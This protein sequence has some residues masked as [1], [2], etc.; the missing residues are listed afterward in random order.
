MSAF[1]HNS[2]SSSPVLGKTVIFTADDFGMSPA[3]NA[4]VALAHRHGVLKCA[5]LMVTGPTAGQAV[6]LAREMPD[7]CLGVHLTLIQ[8]RSALPPKDLPHLVDSQGRF[9]NN[10]V[11][12]GWRY[13]WQAG[14]LP[15]IRRELAAQI[16]AALAK[17]LTIWFLNSH[18]N[19]HL[20]P[21][22]FPVV[23]DLAEEYGI[24]AIRLVR[25]NWRTAISLD[26][27]GFIPKIA[28]GL[29][30]TWLCRKARRLSQAAGLLYNDHLFGLLNDGRM[31]GNYL[32]GLVPHLKP[33][34]TEIY[35]HPALYGDQ[36][37]QR[38]A[39]KYQ[40]REELT[41]LLSPRLKEVLAAAGV[42]VSDFRG[43]LD[44]SHE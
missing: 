16:E 1:L 31:T 37:L 21:R 35:L 40:R 42:E 8:G 30:F 15:E 36:E 33:G 24:P 7:L 27:H 11:R 12:A 26:A 28:Q 43:L 22:I 9:L 32:L 14:L 2:T 17:G 23:T 44:F 41:A 34:V 3:L 4:A 19:L 18:V 6:A 20:H 39:P 29:I 13:Y 10:P 38:W 5:S 25:E